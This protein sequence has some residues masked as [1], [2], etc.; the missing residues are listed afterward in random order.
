MRVN[1]QRNA[2]SPEILNALAFTPVAV[3]RIKPN[4]EL[5]TFGGVGRVEGVVVEGVVVVGVV[6]VVVVV[7]FVV[8]PA[9]APKGKISIWA[10]EANSR[11]IPSRQD[12]IIVEVVI[13]AK[14]SRTS[15]WCLLVALDN[16]V[17]QIDLLD[18]RRRE[19]LQVDGRKL[20]CGTELPFLLARLGADARPSNLA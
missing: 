6:G 16:D 17:T 14:L 12:V 4:I 11:T 10:T 7:A 9:S 18:Q 19:L 20:R 5:A 13:T 15:V 1:P 8:T 2:R 3:I